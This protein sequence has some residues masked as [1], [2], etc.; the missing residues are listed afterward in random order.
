[1]SIISGRCVFYC[2]FFYIVIIFLDIR[3]DATLEGSSMGYLSQE[4]VELPRRVNVSDVKGSD[5][6]HAVISRRK[7]NILFPSGVKLCG[8][9]T[10]QQVVSSHLS[11]FHLRVCQETIWEAFKIFWDRLPEQDE[12]Q[13]WMSQCQEGTVTTQDVGSYFSQSEEHHALVQKRMLLPGL[14]SETTRSWQ[15]MCSTPTQRAPEAVEA[16]EAVEAP[17]LEDKDKGEKVQE[18]AAIVPEAVESPMD[19]D[20]AVQPPSPAGLEQV[21]ELSVLLTGETY[22]DDLGDPASFQRQTLS[23]QFAEKIEDALEGL[24]GFKSMSVLDFRPQKDTEGLDGVV[25]VYT[26][27][28]MV[29]GAGVSTD[30]LDYLT[31]QSNRVENSYREVMALPTVV[32]TISEVKNLNTEALHDD[33]LESVSEVPESVNAADGATIDAVDE[34]PAVTILKEDSEVVNEDYVLPNPS[35][36]N[37]VANTENDVIVLEESA[38]VSPAPGLTI[39]APEAGSIEE[40]GLLPWDTVRTTAVET[41]PPEEHPAELPF[42]ELPEGVTLPEPPVAIEASGSGTDDL[43]DLLHPS[44]PTEEGAVS[45][46]ETGS[47]DGLITEDIAI[48]T[49]A[50]SEAETEDVEVAAVGEELTVAALEEEHLD[51]I[52]VNEAKIPEELEISTIAAETAEE[53]LPVLV[54]PLEAVDEASDAPEPEAAETEESNLTDVNPAEGADINM[55]STYPEEPVF[56]EGGMEEATEREEQEVKE[57]TAPEAPPAEEEGPAAPE[58]STEDLTED[59]ILLVNK[60]ELEP[61]VTDYLSPAEPTALSPERELPFT[62]ISEVD[63]PSEGQPDVVIPSL[64]EIQTTNQ[65]LDDGTVGEQDYDVIHYGY[66]LN[67]HTEE[68]STGF[69]FGVARGTDQVSIAMPVNPGRALMV[70]FSLRVTNMIFSDDLF[71]KSSPEYKALEQRFIELLVPYLQSNLSNFENLEILNFRNGSIVV[72]SRMKFG[73]P[74]PQSVTT[75]VYL[76]LEDFCNTAYQTMNLAIDKY[77]LDVESVLFEPHVGA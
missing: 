38:V 67:N 24:P 19:N 5:E 36:T 64:G 77:S 34:P 50:I 72:N 53:G 46:E 28:V 22:S 48:N 1:M 49:D 66:D 54:P 74:V 51:D 43:E 58:M 42:P 41:L 25:V 29:D 26:V 39:S 15:H 33:E 63:P 16:V 37:T 9:E 12:Y 60:D 8:Q 40:E 27:T 2:V 17:E 13:S 75:T 57:E 21:V 47:E 32:Y 18:A 69:P 14:K 71:N 73:K 45:L 70:F 76:I 23:R 55:V 10:A 4:P 52:V 56:E 65:G 61:P 11:Y 59:E 7:R 20:I 35:E 44:T 68:G 62:R 6:G 31:L 3:T 30:Q